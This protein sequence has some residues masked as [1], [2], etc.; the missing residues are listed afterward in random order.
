MSIDSPE[1]TGRKQSWWT[2]DFKVAATGMKYFAWSNFSRS[3]VHKK[4][5]S[6][7]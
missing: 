5:F 6:L 4:Y 3:L 2:Y 1:S 7:I